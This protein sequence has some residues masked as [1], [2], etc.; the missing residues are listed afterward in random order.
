VTDRPIKL[1]K[2]RD[3][4]V[5]TPSQFGRPA[6][7]SAGSG[8]VCTSRHLYV[9]ADDELQLGVFDLNSEDPGA[10]VPMLAGELPLEPAARK[11]AK[12]DFEA[13]VQLPA[14][15]SYVHGAL[16]ALAS[17]STPNRHQGII[18]PLAANDE[19]DLP[20]TRAIDLSLLHEAASQ[21]IGTVNIE[22]AVAFRDRLLLLQRGNKGAGVNAIVGFDLAALCAA[23]EQGDA[24][25][26]LAVQSVRTYALGT[27]RDIP[28]G[29]T[30]AAVLSD[31]SIVF[32]AIA[33]D[34]D[35]AY[36]DGACAGAALGIIAA[37]GELRRIGPVL[38]S[39][40]I[41]GIFATQ[42]QT[43]LQLLLVTDADDPRI[44]AALYAATLRL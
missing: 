24:I 4:S 3:L 2:V 20:R 30:D 33:E 6:F 26:S 13:L 41:E 14:F 5:Q 44:P 10:L 23:I 18:L 17:G 22:G 8:L 28:L 25:P 40:K 9:I 39:A 7:V 19:I 15:G 42:Q 29:F 38:P 11:R 1:T 35:N 21:E 27:I 34:T 12:P 36:S 32:C 16:F 43:E 37:S 31:G